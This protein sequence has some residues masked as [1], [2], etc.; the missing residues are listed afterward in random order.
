MTW[1]EVFIYWGPFAL[2]VIAVP[3]IAALY[4]E[5]VEPLTN[6]IINKEIRIPIKQYNL[7]L[8]ENNLLRE[9]LEEGREDYGGNIY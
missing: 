6:C 7:I 8:E 2:G 9:K 3:I 1:R 5:F 4:M